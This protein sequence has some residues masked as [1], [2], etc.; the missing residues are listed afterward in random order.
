MTTK[1]KSK[2]A[3]K[4]RAAAKHTLSAVAERYYEAGRGRPP[5]Q[6]AGALY[7][8]LLD[9]AQA[10]ADNADSPYE[11]RAQDLVTRA[12]TTE[13]GAILAAAPE[14]LAALRAMVDCHGGERTWSYTRTAAQILADARAA[15]AKAE[16][17]E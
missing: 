2:G 1:A 5:P 13:E 9:L 10:I 8:E 16:G 17:K 15:I 4:D 11:L 6:P 12:T 7:L 3:G 14:L